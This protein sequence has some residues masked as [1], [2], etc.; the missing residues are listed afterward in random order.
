MV[1]LYLANG[2]LRQA[3]KNVH[4]LN[5]VGEKW[6]KYRAV[7]SRQDTMYAVKPLKRN[8]QEG[9]FIYCQNPN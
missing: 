7:R 5:S 6:T 4:P 2:D 9:S 1:E 8:S 3:K